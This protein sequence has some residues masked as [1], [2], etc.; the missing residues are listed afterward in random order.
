[1]VSGYLFAMDLGSA[2]KEISVIKRNGYGEGNV[3][4]EL[5][6]TV[7]GKQQEEMV[8][9]NVSERQYTD[10]ELQSIF[11]RSV[12]K[13]EALMLGENVSLDQIQMKLNLVR[14]IPDEPVL[15]EWEI[16]RYDIV[17]AYGEINWENVAK[18]GALVQL[19]AYLQYEQDETKQMLH[20]M[21]VRIG[22]KEEQKEQLVA[23][24]Q[25]SLEQAEEQTVTEEYV[26]L[27][28][29]VDGQQLIFYQPMERRSLGVLLWG[30]LFSVLI[31][32]MD[33][34]SR[35]DREKKREEQMM[36]DYPEVIGKLNL[37]LGA[38]FTVKNA[39]KKILD[40]Y[41]KQK[42]IQGM[43]YVYEEMANT[44]REMQSGIL[45]AECYE[46]FGRNC[47]L[48]SYRKLGALLSQNL[49]KGTKGLSGLLNLEAIQA[50]EERKMR[51]KRLGEEAETKL[52]MP[53][54]LMLTVVLVIVI[55][56]AFMAIQV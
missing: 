25:T 45:E 42:D 8:Q 14:S 37:L 19:K 2:E 44:Y 11:T 10:E 16:D 50:Y 12:P 33:G 5:E 24:V 28:R 47:K 55:V 17:N 41:E 39:W 22:S 30:I 56:P 40:D 3:S 51:A 34:Q 36:R 43:R 23:T 27:P 53:M 7:D 4:E 1:M 52:L 38:G 6:V 48:K 29:E 20:V 31:W 26:E 13:L 15:V 18:E 49:R 54:F 32:C 35:K 46:H 9:L 21:N